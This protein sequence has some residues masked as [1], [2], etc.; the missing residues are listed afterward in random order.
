[1]DSLL[2]VLY[3]N[4]KPI[5]EEEVIASMHYAISQIFR[6]HLLSVTFTD[7]VECNLLACLHRETKADVPVQAFSALAQGAKELYHK[8]TWNDFW[9]PCLDGEVCEVTK[10]F[11]SGFKFYVGASRKKKLIRYMNLLRRAVYEL[12]RFYRDF[13]ADTT[14]LHEWIINP[15]MVVVLGTRDRVDCPFYELA[16]RATSFAS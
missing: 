7:E 2:G 10:D 8:G 15:V 4:D 6:V 1:M 5:T 12:D 14:N 9:T 11:A 16:K 3:F 13:P